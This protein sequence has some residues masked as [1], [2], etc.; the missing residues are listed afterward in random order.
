MH[1]RTLLKSAAAGALFIRRKA[2]AQVTVGS[3][4]MAQTSARD[5]LEACLERIGDPRGEGARTCL[6]IYATEARAAADA[7]DARARAGHS[8]GPMDGKVVAAKDLFDIAG[9]TTRAGSTALRDAPPA[10]TDATVIRRLRSA[11]AVIVAKVNMSEFAFTAFGINPHFGTPGNPADRA[12]VPGGSSSGS[13]VAAA[14]GMCDIGIGSDTGGSCRIPAALCGT[15]GY[16]PSKFRIPTAGAFPLSFTL[17]SIGPV[18]RSVADCAAADAVMADDSPWRVESISLS[19]LRLGISQG[20]PLRNLDS[21]VEA[22]FSQAIVALERAGARLSDEAMPILDE[23]ARVQAKASFSSVESYAL[24]R[25]LL[26]QHGDDFDPM[27]RAR[28]EAGRDISAADYIDMQRQRANLVR[29]MDERLEE[30]D[31]LIMPTVPIVAPKIVD[32]SDPKAAREQNLLLLR[33][34]A[35]A[36]FF[37]LCSISLPLP[38]QGGLP[39]GVMVFARNGQDR[40]LFRIAAAMERLYT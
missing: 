29:A 17:D 25:K 39:T 18:A 38:R 27:V 2:L 21:T 20:L 9:E 10:S 4:P 11:G 15:V 24:H 28:I 19:N 6:T 33:N 12:R 26:M 22:H 8:L 40:Q 32:L 7:A 23:P 13:T 31:G 1:R 36:N 3:K 35:L 16:K 14:D 34:P 30:L 37:D 5:H